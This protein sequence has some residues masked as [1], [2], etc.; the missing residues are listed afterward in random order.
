MPFL[1]DASD[2]L[3]ATLKASDAVSVTIR[4]GASVSAPVLAV[5]GRTEF[6]QQTEEGTAV[7]SWQGEDYLIDVADYVLGG[8]AV[9]PEV[10][11]EI[12]DTIAGQVVIQQ[13][14]SPGGEPPW[15]YVGPDQR[16]YRLHT[17][18]VGVRNEP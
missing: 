7:A 11:D 8:V 15:R 5:R 9:T 16:Q 14:L 18:R 12:F 1:D 6:V 3:S 17:K 4:R 10:G 13:V 2:W